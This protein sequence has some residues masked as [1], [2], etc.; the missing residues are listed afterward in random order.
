MY[1]NEK[2]HGLDKNKSGVKDDRYDL[3]FPFA[4][5]FPF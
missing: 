4:L 2:R 1:D 3:F 5:S